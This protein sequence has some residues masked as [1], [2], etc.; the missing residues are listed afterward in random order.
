MEDWFEKDRAFGSTGLTLIGSRV[1]DGE[2]KI[3]TKYAKVNLDE[4]HERQRKSEFETRGA[5]LALCDL[6]RTRFVVL[7]REEWR[8]CRA[9]G[10]SLGTRGN[11]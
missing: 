11:F 5:L 8:I 10:C 7:R 9:F 4:L 3:V 1:H 6:R 2:V